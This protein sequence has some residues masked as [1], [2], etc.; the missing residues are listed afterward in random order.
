[1]IRFA[2]ACA[3]SAL[4]MGWVAAAAQA[5]D[6]S[7]PI[8]ID[9]KIAATQP[10]G[11]PAHSAFADCNQCQNPCDAY[12]LYA[13]FGV[14]YLE[15]RWV[16]NPAFFIAVSNPANGN[17]SV[18]QQDFGVDG[19]FAP[20]AAIGVMLDDCFGARIR[21]SQF[22][23]TGFNESAPASRV[24]T[25]F[26]ATPLGLQV[27]APA[28]FSLFALGDIRTQLWDI[29]VTQEFHPC[30]CRLVASAGLRAGRVSQ[31]YS[32]AVANGAGAVTSSLISGHSFE[33][34]G[35][36]VGLEG[37]RPIGCDGFGLY[38][39]ARASLLFGHAKESASVTR[40]LVEGARDFDAAA[41]R[42]SLLP[43]LDIELGA[44]Y[45][46]SLGDACLILQAGLVGQVWFNAENPSLTDG[47]TGGLQ[48]PPILGVGGRNTNFGF[49]G[50][51]ISA[52]IRF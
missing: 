47:V 8:P 52:G 10:A 36:T 23:D 5:D 3:L 31:D 41:S 27:F 51:N 2:I 34:I 44:E 38:G 13:E 26:S 37:H 21:W 1:M 20:H 22:E 18:R 30:H 39:L 4:V 24:S 43:M 17:I 25:A 28:G 40:A 42:E 19:H 49:I 12:G 35:P 29:E 32:A 6:K 9:Q 45:T 14:Y 50:F 7:Q 11:A 16:S 15:P 48:A 33:G 46:T